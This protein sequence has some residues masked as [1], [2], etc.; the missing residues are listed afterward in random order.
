MHIDGTSSQTAFTSIRFLRVGDT[1]DPITG[2]AIHFGEYVNATVFN[3]IGGGI[4]ECFRLGANCFTTINGGRVVG[5]TTS[6]IHVEDYSTVV[7][8][9][10]DLLQESSAPPVIFEGDNSSIKLVGCIYDDSRCQIENRSN[11]SAVINDSQPGERAFLITEE[12]H[13]GSPEYGR[14]TALGQGDSY[15]RGMLV[16]N[17][18]GSSYTDITE[19]V[20][21]VS[22]SVFNGFPNT[23]VNTAMY[24]CSTLDDGNLTVPGIRV[25]VS[26][27]AS[28]GEVVAEYY[29]GSSW[30]EFNHMSTDSSN[31]YLPYAKAIFQRA[32]REQVRFDNDIRELQSKSDP[33]SLGTS[34]YW[35]RFRIVS[36][37]SV[38]PQ[39]DKIKIHTDRLEI[40]HDGFVEYFG[41]ARPVKALSFTY[42]SFE[43]AND[44]PTNQDLYYDDILAAGRIENEFS[45]SSI[46]TRSDKT[47]LAE[48]LPIDIDT[49]CKVKLQITFATQNSPS[50]TDQVGFRVYWNKSRDGDNVYE[51]SRSSPS[52]SSGRQEQ[53]MYT[54]VTEE[55]TQYTMYTDLDFSDFS[56]RDENDISDLVWLA[57]VRNDSIDTYSDLVTVMQIRLLYVCANEGGHL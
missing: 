18:D 5:Y 33:M 41:Q 25:D 13:V 47:A 36:A 38:A 54:S 21:T 17:Y 20:R 32:Q 10:L 26:T 16:Y 50:G 12:L 4:A 57:I 45:K 51:T 23:S 7:V 8:N 19:D 1:V 9:G 49:S 31:K 14:E 53:N 15:V 28:G 52:V 35:I 6:A 42:N 11:Y 48:F 56:P 34:Y 3:M 27:A 2:T 24:I 44:S 40:N 37:L 30:V 29:D 43:A 46:L 39:F 55:D 22:D